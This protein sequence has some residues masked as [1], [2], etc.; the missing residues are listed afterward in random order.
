MVDRLV[1]RRMRRGCVALCDGAHRIAV[2]VLV[3]LG[4][5]VGVLGLAGLRGLAATLAALSA[6]ASAFAPS[7]FV[8][9][10]ALASALIASPLASPLSVVLVA[11]A[12]TA[13]P[14]ELP[15]TADKAPTASNPAAAA[16]TVINRSMK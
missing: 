8:S 1:S 10:L 16:T 11:S 14:C 13:F 2:R 3:S 5:L 9:P 12:L 4:G 15:A 6:F 7:D